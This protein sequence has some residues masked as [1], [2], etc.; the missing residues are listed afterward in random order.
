MIRVLQVLPGL[1][2]GGLETFVMNVYRTIDRNQIQFDFLTNMKR[3]DYS[4]EIKNLGGR[5]FYISPRNNGIKKYCSNL[6]DF[7]DKN[8][9]SYNAIH[10]HE[11][12]L[13]SLEIL[14]YAKRA[15]IPVRIMHAHSSSIM[16]SN[17]HYITHYLGK[18]AISSLANRYF[19]CS[20]KALDWMYSYTGVRNK[21]EIINNG[22]NISLF[23]FKEDKR[24]KIRESLGL[25]ESDFVIGHVGRFSRVKNHSFLIDIFQELSELDKKYKLILV[26]IGELEEGIKEKVEKLQLSDSVLFLGLR[27]D[28]D[29]IYQ[30][31]DMF[32]M[33]SFYEGLPVVL[34]EAQTSG[35]PVLCSDR[36]SKMSKM[37]DN[38]TMMSI[39]E[40]PFLW[41]NYIVNYNHN[42]DRTTAYH[43][44]IEKGYDINSVVK[45]LSMT[46]SN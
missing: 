21:A 39:D 18:L 25:S 29:L 45:K 42:V 7:F 8:G 32:V 14:F 26:G 28:T 46:Y 9:S 35:L 12:S 3:G 1:N 13:T 2:R 41:A 15:K 19:G 10:Y 22:I 20:D 5:I 34:V 30:G 40:K 31:L 38:F 43:N 27:E 36:I 37:S 44:I 23:K 16:G 17:L 33:P 4:D 24:K 6:K 11:S